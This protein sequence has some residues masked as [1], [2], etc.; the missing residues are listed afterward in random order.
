MNGCDSELGC[1]R[2]AFVNASF[3]RSQFFRP[4]ETDVTLLSGGHSC[5]FQPGKNLF[6]PLQKFQLLKLYLNRLAHDLDLTRRKH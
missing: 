3:D 4:L 2:F 5:H 1:I 6:S